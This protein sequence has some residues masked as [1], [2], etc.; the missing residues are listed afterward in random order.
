LRISNLKGDIKKEKGGR[1]T[2]LFYLWNVPRGTI[3]YENKNNIFHPV[4][5]GTRYTSIYLILLIN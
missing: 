5:S 1:N 2:F 3:V 4:L